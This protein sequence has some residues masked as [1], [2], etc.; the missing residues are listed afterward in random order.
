[1]PAIALFSPDDLPEDSGK[2]RKRRNQRLPN[3]LTLDEQEQIIAAAHQQTLFA[4]S[5]RKLYT[6]QVD[7]VLVHLG[8]YAGLRISEMCNLL[9]EDLDFT[10][11]AERIKVVLGKGG[12]DRFVPI[13][14]KLL[15]V[16]RGWLVDRTSGPVVL[17]YGGEVLSDGT[18]YW[19]ICRL[20]SLSR[21]TKHIHPHI[22][23]H[24]FATRLVEN[25]TPLPMIQALMGHANLQT[26][27]VYLHCDPSYLR[28]AID[29]IP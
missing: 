28:G 3:F 12:K 22:L 6:S 1:M 24:T 11:G 16:I 5:A 18:A 9:V 19:R 4:T 29:G 7:C 27:S 14:Q 17:T 8:I 23:R 10:A 2:K 25:K 21:I 13:H 15:A 26:T 20:G